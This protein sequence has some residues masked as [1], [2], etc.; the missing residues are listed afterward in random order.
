MFLGSITIGREPTA[1]EIFRKAAMF[2]LIML[3]TY[4]THADASHFPKL[5]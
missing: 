5:S 2:L 3:Q 1:K 4:I